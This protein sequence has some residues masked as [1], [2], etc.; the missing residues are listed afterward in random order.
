MSQ[1]YEPPQQPYPPAAGLVG[2]SGDKRVGWA[3]GLSIAALAAALIALLAVFAGFAGSFFAL[4][5]SHGYE[6]EFDSPPTDGRR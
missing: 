3:I 4:D 6:G 5:D 1:V 2:R